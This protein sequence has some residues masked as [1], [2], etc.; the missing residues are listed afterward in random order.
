MSILTGDDLVLGTFVPY[1]WL[2]LTKNHWRAPAPPADAVPGMIFSDADDDKLYHC[3][4]GSGG[5][6]DEILQATKSADVA[7]VFDGVVLDIKSADVS[8]PP[9]QG[10][11]DAVFGSGPGEGFTG[12]VQDSSSGGSLWLCTMSGGLW[13]VIEYTTAP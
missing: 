7:P 5:V 2:N 13:R 3:V 9:T 11:L 10:E 8:D 4:A 12:L 1:Q 6:L